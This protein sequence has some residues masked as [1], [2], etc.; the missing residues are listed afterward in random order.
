M[1]RLRQVL[2]MVGILL[3]L[4]YTAW[5]VYDKEQIL[6]DGDLV[7]FALAPVDPRSLLQ[8]DFMRLRYEIGDGLEREELPTRG[9]LVYRL[10]PQ[11]VA[12]FARI[13]LNP[14]PL[15][16]GEGIIQFRRRRAGA[17]R[18]GTISLGAESY[19]FEEGSAEKY[20][21]ASYG[22]MRINQDGQA[23]LVGLWDADLRRIR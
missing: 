2:P 17:I 18:N 19:F 16:A 23:V 15:G 22:G 4:G 13:Q 21:R 11:G 20:G 8:G 10:D 9:F 3:V 7:L 12:R 5:F 14:T 6:S 1:N